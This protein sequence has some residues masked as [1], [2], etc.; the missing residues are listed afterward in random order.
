MK[1]LLEGAERREVQEEN[2]ERYELEEAE[3][4]EWSMGEEVTWLEL[5]PLGVGNGVK[6]VETLW[7][8][9]WWQGEE[10]N[11]TGQEVERLEENAEGMLE[12]LVEEKPVVV[13]LEELVEEKPVVVTLVVAMQAEMK[14]VVLNSTMLRLLEVVVESLE[15]FQ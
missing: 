5:V 6:G 15:S 8:V 9:R 12:G 10:N 11:L 4:K 14:L 13:M 7:E 1:Q 3:I 2:R